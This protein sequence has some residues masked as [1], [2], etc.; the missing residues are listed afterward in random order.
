MIG[1]VDV[2]GGMRCVYSSGVYDRLLD[3]NIMIPY[4]LGV[5]AGAA[6]LIT[7]VAGQ[8][9]RTL[10]FY[11]E[12]AKRKEYMSMKNLLSTGSYISLDYIYSTLS[13]EDG[14][15]PLDFDTF[16]KSDVIFKA[17]TT[18]A[19]DGKGVFFGNSDII[20]N[21]YTVLKASCCLPGICRP[22]SLQNDLYFD[23]GVAEPIPV[24]KAFEDGCDKVIL[25]LTKSRQEYCK[26]LFATKVLSSRIRKYSDVY[27]LMKALPVRCKEILDKVATWEKEGKVLVIEPSDCFGANTLTREYETLTKLYEEGYSDAE[28]IIEFINS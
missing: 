21:D 26:P 17:A 9:G 8:R 6:N 7:Y 13:N 14:E 19:R 11:R 10:P 24:D 27:Q 2:G 18:R 23:G 3:E 20:R 12:Y 5:S 1:I 28:K 15:N 25:V 4:C 22:V 16:S